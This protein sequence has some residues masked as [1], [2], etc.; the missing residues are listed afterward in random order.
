MFRVRVELLLPERVGLT[1]LDLRRRLGLP[2]ASKLE[3]D[4]GHS[5]VVEVS[6]AVARELGGFET[7]A[8][9]VFYVRDWEA[10]IPGDVVQDGELVRLR[11]RLPAE[12]VIALARAANRY[13]LETKLAERQREAEELLRQL[14][15]LKRD[16]REL[17]ERRDP[18]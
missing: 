1:A 2:E 11:D 17:E 9:R 6:E 10:L 5:V 18:C 3:A 14:Q 16:L 13:V 8:E 7:T 4:R 15:V 12:R